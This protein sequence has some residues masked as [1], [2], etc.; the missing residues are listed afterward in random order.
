M[1]VRNAGGGLAG[2]RLGLIGAGNMAEALCRAVL[3]AGLV[4]ADKI[5]AS[6]VSAERRDFFQNELGVRALADNR[7]VVSDSDVLVLAVKPQQMPDMLGEIGP[8][9]SESVLVMTIAAG[10]K[11]AA[12]EQA[13]GGD[14][15]VIRVMP[16]T[17]M[18]IG[19]GMAALCKGRHASDQDLETAAEV[20]GSAG[21]TVRVDEAMMDAVTALS[22]S[23]PAYFFYF[24]EAMIEA[25]VAEGLGPD[26]A[27]L[28]ARQ[29][30]LGA[31]RLLMVSDDSPEE[32]RR[33]VTSPGGTTEAAVKQMTADGVRDEIVR[34]VRAAAAR[35]RALG[36]T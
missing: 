23:G 8:L 18:L 34:A 24:V 35:S 19:E 22:G 32:L 27:A 2:R 5:L 11:A 10:V 9:L 7:A 31:G 15:R 4:P 6:D 25:G 16:N 20:F 14:C 28:L 3:R 13:A 17:P 29:A 1:T 26:V 21:R 30:A 12:I 33:K 36:G